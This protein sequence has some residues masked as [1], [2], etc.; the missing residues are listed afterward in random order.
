VAKGGEGSV[1]EKSEECMERTHQQV[2]VVVVEAEK[3]LLEMYPEQVEETEE[4]NT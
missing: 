3:R 2:R 4:Y 1:R